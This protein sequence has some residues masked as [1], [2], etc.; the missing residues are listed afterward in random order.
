MLHEWE[1]RDKQLGRKHFIADGI[2]NEDIWFNQNESDRICFFLKEAYL[3]E[4]E[5][6]ANYDWNLVKDSLDKGIVKKMWHTVAEWTYGI[7]NTTATHIPQYYKLS[8][9]T[10]I[11]EIKKIAVVNPKKSDGNPNTKWDE[12]EDIVKNDGTFDL[13]K[14]EIEIINPKVLIC[15]NNVSLLYNYVFKDIDI[16]YIRSK[17]YYWRNEMLIIDH[18]HPA[19][20]FPNYMNYYTLCVLYQQAIKE[21]MQ[22]NG[23]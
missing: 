17:H 19:N 4:E 7:H 13:I 5:K 20:Q 16:D 9:E 23:K 8:K 22:Y 10:E 2:V 21:R 1:E 14:R 6:K 11:K 18:Y 12:L 15:G 3:S